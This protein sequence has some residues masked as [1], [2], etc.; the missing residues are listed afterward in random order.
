[1]TTSTYSLGFNSCL[2]NSHKAKKQEMQ[3]QG[4]FRKVNF[5][6]IWLN[7]QLLRSWTLLKDS[8]NLLSALSKPVGCLS[9]HRRTCSHRSVDQ[10]YCGGDCTKEDFNRRRAVELKHGRLCMFAAW[11]QGSGNEENI[12]HP[13][14]KENLSDSTVPAGGGDMLVFVWEGTQSCGDENWY[15]PR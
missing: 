12:S 6:K 13:L 8:F 9:T 5:F 15:L 7:P 14:E 2:K 10:G 3:P 11:R 4:R 1:M